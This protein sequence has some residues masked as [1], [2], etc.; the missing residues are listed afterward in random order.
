MELHNRHLGL[1]KDARER[2]SALLVA[3]A[4]TV[5]VF[6]AIN[7]GFTPHATRL[8]GSYGDPPALSL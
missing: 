3:V 8:V 2:I 5:L 6:A 7:A 1:G 4:A